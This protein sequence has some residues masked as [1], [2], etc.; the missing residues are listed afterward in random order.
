MLTFEL[1]NLPTCFTQA[2]TSGI[3]ECLND[4]NQPDYMSKSPTHY[5]FSDRQ[6]CCNKHYAWSLTTC[7]GGSD[8]IDLGDAQWYMDWAGQAG[9][10]CVMNCP[11]ENADCG[12]LAESWDTLWSSKEE[13]CKKM[14][15][16]DA[17]CKTN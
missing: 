10:D 4:G 6:A 15:W 12:G 3:N 9:G 14:K 13:C 7:L 1:P 17:S 11:Q 16:W 5:L 8:S 2:W